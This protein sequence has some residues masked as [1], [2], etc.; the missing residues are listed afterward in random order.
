MGTLA[1]RA[2]RQ[3]RKGG[4]HARSRSQDQAGLPDA[5]T[6]TQLLTRV[7]SLYYE[8]NRTQQ[9]IAEQLALTR[10]NVSRLLTEARERGIVGIR[11]QHLLPSPAPSHCVQGSNSATNPVL[12]H[13]RI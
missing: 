3:V 6:G 5:G 12:P 9:E 1:K 13:R 2:P 10:S 8:P 4:H 11:V 7:A